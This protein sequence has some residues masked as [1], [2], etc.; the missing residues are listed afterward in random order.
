MTF[1]LVIDLVLRI[2]PF[3]S[4]VYYVKCR[5]WPFPH[6]KNTIFTLFILSRTSDNT[7]SQNIGGTNAW[8]VPPRQIFGGTVPPVPLGL[9]PWIHWRFF[10]LLFTVLRFWRPG[11]WLNRIGVLKVLFRKKVRHL[12]ESNK[13]SETLIDMSWKHLHSP[14]TLLLFSVKKSLSP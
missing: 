3:F 2:F 10:Q 13:V 6:K 5:I 11:Q 8:A 12:N 14:A 7:A 9:R 4:P 1:F